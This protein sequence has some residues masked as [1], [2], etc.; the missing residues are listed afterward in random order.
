MILTNKL[1]AALRIFLAALTAFAVLCGMMFFYRNSPLREK[2][3]YEN[4]DYVWEPNT[5][6]GGMNEGVSF[7]VIDGQ[8]FNNQSVVEHPDILVLGSSHTEGRNVMQGNDFT[9]RLNKLLGGSMTAYNMGMSGHTLY[10]V[11]QYLPVSLS[12]YQPA[13]KYVVIETDDTVLDSKAVEMSINGQVKKTAVKDNGAMAMLQKLPYIRAFYR[14]LD[15]GMLD[16][17]LPEMKAKT[18]TAASDAKKDAAPDEAAYETMFAHLEKLQKESG[19]T[20]IIMYHP[21]EVLNGDGSLGFEDEAYTAVFSQYAQ[22]HG[23]SFVNMT[24]DFAKMY[25]EE[26]HVPHGFNT[27]EIGWGHLNDYGHAAI[28]ERLYQTISESEGK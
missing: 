23:I 9:D 25:A 26:R 12:I 7:G 24:D 2:S 20:F 16:M 10:K 19:V 17:L 11:V 1:K 4:T 28:A 18:Q 27:G 22:K 15:K 14:Q 8:G 13:P 21:F 5:F 3:R 6:W